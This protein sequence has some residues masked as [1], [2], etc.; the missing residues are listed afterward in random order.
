MIK[1]YFID[2][3]TD[4][5]VWGVTE[6]EIKNYIKLPS[7]I[8][9]DNDLITDIKIAATKKAQR[10]MNRTIATTTYKMTLDTQP[11]NFYIPLGYLQ[12][13]EDILV[14]AED[15]STTSQAGKY[16]TQ[17][18]EGGR[19]WLNTAASWTVTTRDYQ[20]MEIEFKSGYLVTANSHPTVPY[21]MKLGLLAWCKHLY[22]HRDI[23]TVPEAAKRLLLPFRILKV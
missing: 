9:A 1:R 21:D 8:T 20:L 3:D 14:Y 7:T 5:T 23:D 19:V 6:D 10:W 15:N 12:S 11:N 13:I 16:H 4:A 2:L 18:G 17:T 22:F